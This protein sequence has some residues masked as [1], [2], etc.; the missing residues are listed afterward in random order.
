MARTFRVFSHSVSLE[1]EIA[2]DSSPLPGKLVRE[3]K[4]PDSSGIPFGYQRETLAR[5]QKQM[6]WYVQA[7]HWPAQAA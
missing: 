4:C 1:S 7:L 6:R 2:G 5:S 3:P